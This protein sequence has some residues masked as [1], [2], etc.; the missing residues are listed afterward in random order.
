MILQHLPMEAPYAIID[1]RCLN[2]PQLSWKATALLC[3]LAAKPSDWEVNV[4]QLTKAKKGGRD[5]VLS[6]LRELMDTGYAAIV[7][8]RR[9]NGTIWSR[10]YVVSQCPDTLTKF[11][12]ANARVNAALQPA[13]PLQAEPA[14][15]NPDQPI[16]VSYQDLKEKPPLEDVFLSS[17]PEEK[18]EEDPPPAQPPEELVPPP[19]AQGPVALVPAP[20]APVQRADPTSPASPD[21]AA[22]PQPPRGPVAPVYQN[23]VNRAPADD[24]EV[25]PVCLVEGHLWNAWGCKSHFCKRPGCAVH[26][27]DCAGPCCTA[28]EDEPILR[29]FDLLPLEYQEKLMVEVRASYRGGNIRAHLARVLREARPP[30]G[31]GDAILMPKEPDDDPLRE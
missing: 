15:A 3:Y 6:G 21:A 30:T 22:R 1:K 9:A 19:A 28:P 8:T 16:L 13:N 31:P 27:P 7:T 5:C 11:I 20:T 14:E 23:G 4:K 12:D 10:R 25:S 29:H 26:H 2:N 24:P 18:D 17:L